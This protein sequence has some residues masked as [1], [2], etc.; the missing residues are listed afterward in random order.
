MSWR[1]KRLWL[2]SEP[3]G[4]NA[5]SFLVQDPPSR[6]GHDLKFLRIQLIDEPF[7]REIERSAAAHSGALS[8]ASVMKAP[9]T[10]APDDC[11]GEIGQKIFGCR[12]P[13]GIAT[14]KRFLIKDGH[15]MMKSL[16]ERQGFPR[17]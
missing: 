2:E 17:S 9:A 15:R 5:A 4:A 12:L 11:A 10:G 16:P 3:A 8:S 13:V 6:A 7:R 1:V 14:P